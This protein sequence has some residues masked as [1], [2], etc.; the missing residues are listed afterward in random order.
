MLIGL[1]EQPAEPQLSR[2]VLKSNLRSKKA[3]SKK[4][5]KAE[6][7]KVFGLPALFC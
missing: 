1:F 5:K 7:G 2:F 3:K 4:A 6:R